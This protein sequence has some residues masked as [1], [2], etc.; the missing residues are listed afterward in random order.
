MPRVKELG[1]HALSNT[2]MWRLLQNLNKIGKTSRTICPQEEWFI[3]IEV[4]KA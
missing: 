1:G 2:G 4:V 3:E